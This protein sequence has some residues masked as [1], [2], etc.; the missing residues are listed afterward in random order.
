[1]RTT[2]WLSYDLGIR[3]DYDGLYTWLDGLGAQ[4]CGDSL[5]LVRYEHDGD[6]LEELRDDLEEELTLTKRTRIY[7]VYTDPASKR[8]KGRFLFGGRRSAPWSGFAQ[9]EQEIDEE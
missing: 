8:A 7:V 6:I 4:E 3:G 1:M 9:E 5:A 2:I